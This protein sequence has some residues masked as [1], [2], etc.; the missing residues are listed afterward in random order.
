MSI[1][2]PVTPLPSTT[3]RPEL[4]GQLS[5]KPSRRPWVKLLCTV[6]DE[7]KVDRVV[8]IYDVQPIPPSPTNYPNQPAVWAR[9]DAD[10]LYRFLKRYKERTFMKMSSPAVRNPIQHKKLLLSPGG[11]YSPVVF[12]PE[13]KDAD[14]IVYMKEKTSIT[15]EG[16]T[17]EVPVNCGV[18]LQQKTS[19]TSGPQS[20]AANTR[21][22][23]Q[24]FYVV[25]F[26]VQVEQWRYVKCRA[27]LMRPCFEEITSDDRLKTIRNKQLREPFVI[28]AEKLTHGQ[29]LGNESVLVEVFD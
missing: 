20:G 2:P 24:A 28:G 19:R 14:R 25:E 7:F 5:L 26:Y 13:E 11:T 27:G 29:R 4:E 21:N 6:N 23:N 8:Q 22:I 15:F 17:L 18:T 12:D 16:K 1:P 9:S 10:S 3:S